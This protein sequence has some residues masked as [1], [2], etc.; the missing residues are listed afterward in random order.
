MACKHVRNHLS[1][2][3][4][5]GPTRLHV[6]AGWRA[7]GC[8]LGMTDAELEPFASAFEHSERDAALRT[9]S[10]RKS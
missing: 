2:I 5:D 6:V 3:R 8:S 1:E 4:C 10:Q 7:E 9:H